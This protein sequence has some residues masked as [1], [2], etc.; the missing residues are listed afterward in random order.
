[1]EICKDLKCSD[2]VHVNDNMGVLSTYS[3]TDPI[4]GVVKR[5]K[6]YYKIGQYFSKS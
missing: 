3:N 5:K 6:E 1:M 4:N 2:I